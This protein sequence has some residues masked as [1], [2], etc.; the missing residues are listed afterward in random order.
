MSDI[1]R[2]LT[3]EEYAELPDDGTW[4]ELINGEIVRF[5]FPDFLHGLI[6]GNVIGEFGQAVDHQGYLCANT[7]V[8]TS[9][10]PDSVRAADLVF[11]L[12]DRVP[13]PLPT[14]YF[15][16]PPDIVV[17]VKSSFDEWPAWSAKIE[18]FRGCGVKIVTAI[19][20]EARQAIHYCRGC[21]E[22][23]VDSAGTLDFGDVLPGV[24]FALNALLDSE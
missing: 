20:P 7:G 18:A 13:R 2:G 1:A 24:Q 6:C 3:V 19:D 10:S 16:P 22:R 8:I 14:G 9:R 17:E 15:E 21:S 11:W 4:T 12:R 23:I 5:P